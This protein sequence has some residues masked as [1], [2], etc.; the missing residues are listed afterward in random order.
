MKTY[1]EFL[2]YVKENIVDFMPPEYSEAVVDIVKMTK[3]NTQRRNISVSRGVSGTV[4]W[5]N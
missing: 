5:Q 3:D 4:L 2:E 1:S